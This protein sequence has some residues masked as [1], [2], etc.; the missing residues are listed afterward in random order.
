[1]STHCTYQTLEVEERGGICRIVLHRPERRNALTAEMIR[2][3]TEALGAVAAGSASVLILTGAGE[4]F[5]S[6]LDLE[7]LKTM[8][9]RTPEE[10]RADSAAIAT[11]LRTL[12][13][14]PI[15]TVA[16]VNGAAVAGG[17]GLATVCDFTYA[18]PEAKFGY[19]E[20]RIGFIPAI[21]SA[22]L[23]Q[24]VGEKQAR[25]L[26][27]T[28]RLIEAAEAHALGLVTRVVKQTELTGEV[29]RLAELLLR[30]SPGS[31]RATKALLNAQQRERLDTAL[32]AAVEA[33]AALRETADFREG[34]ASFL[35]KRRPVWPSRSS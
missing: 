20:V 8:A 17:M 9:G 5:C 1:M 30:N 23:V 25:D 12:Y 3:L 14:L 11:L 22:F 21:V 4:A 7:E 16:A 35:E 34:L 27:L 24:Q 31:L 26:L 6:G 28:G 15:P 33:N 32:Q 29:D 18:V 10:N 19:T 13:D 2:E